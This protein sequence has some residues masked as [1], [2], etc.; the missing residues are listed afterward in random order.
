ML[1]SFSLYITG[2][3]L[4]KTLTLARGE[5][6]SESCFPTSI[7]FKDEWP[8]D[9]SAGKLPTSADEIDPI[10]EFYGPGRDQPI[11]LDYKYLSTLSKLVDF[12]PTVPTKFIIHGFGNTLNES[13]WITDMRKAFQIN[14]DYNIVLVGWDTKFPDYVQAVCN[15]RFV[16]TIT[17]NVIN[18]LQRKGLDLSDLHLIGHSL[19]AHICSYVGRLMRSR[20]ARIT[21]LD[22]AGPWFDT[23]GEEARLDP[24]DAQFVDV[25]HSNGHSL[26]LYGGFGLLEQS[27]HVDFYPNGGKKQPGCNDGLGGGSETFFEKVLSGNTE[28]F[29]ES[30]LKAVGCSHGRAYEI[31]TESINA[32][33]CHFQSYSCPTYDEFEQGLCSTCGPKGCNYAGLEASPFAEVGKQ[34]FQTNSYSPYCSRSVQVTLTPSQ[35]ANDL[36]GKLSL[37][38]K[39]TTGNDTVLLAE[40]D[41][42]MYPQEPWTIVRPIKNGIGDIVSGAII[43]DRSHFFSRRRLGVASLTVKDMKTGKRYKRSSGFLVYSGQPAIFSLQEDVTRS[44]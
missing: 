2:S 14:G 38:V 12:D 28:D 37:Y 1:R 5:V 20:I 4:L 25:I 34:F 35:R 19:G 17:V 27:G 44:L 31:F 9:T 32:E 30:V 16:A 42:L 8:F 43:Y 3:I 7:G 15:S 39:G 36:S 10:F 18:M 40:G 23:F 11:N 41:I 22:P 26:S 33:S 24:S 29:E 6:D 13:E 21:G